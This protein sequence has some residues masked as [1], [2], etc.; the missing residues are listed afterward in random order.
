MQMS[1]QKQAQN[2]NFAAVLALVCILIVTADL[3]G[4]WHYLR[5]FWHWVAKI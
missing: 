4:F 3:Q 2:C 1:L 5:F